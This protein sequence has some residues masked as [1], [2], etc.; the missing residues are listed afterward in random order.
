MQMC[1]PA[2]G[3]KKQFSPHEQKQQKPVK[4]GFHTILIMLEVTLQHNHPSC[5]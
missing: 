1:R 5:L 2:I 3:S 4:A